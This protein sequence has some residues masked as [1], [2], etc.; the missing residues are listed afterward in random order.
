MKTTIV[1][2]DD[3]ELVAEALAEAINKMSDFEVLYTCRHGAA[4]QAAFAEKKNFPHLIL[5]DIQLPVMDG[6]ETCLWLK[7]Y[8]SSIKILAITSLTNEE[9]LKKMVA[10]GALGYIEKSASLAELEFAFQ[11][12][13]SNNYYL[14]NWATKIH[15]N[16]II[17]DQW[18]SEIVF[19][20]REKEFLIH[21][22]SEISYKEIAKIM[23]INIR[24]VESIREL[25]AEK[26]QIKTRV[27]L[28]MFAIKQGFVKEYSFQENKAKNTNE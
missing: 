7:N 25:V 17:D 11:K 22:V 9:S 13:M 3:H 20:K 2:V 6:Y 15:V 27:G 12:V 10:N 24:T 26:T 5:L 14:P 8:H 4:L 1:I 28:A 18:P 23:N 19:T 21:C 16:R